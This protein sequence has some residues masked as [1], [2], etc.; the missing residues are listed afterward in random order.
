MNGILDGRL[1]SYLSLW[2]IDSTMA[3]SSFDKTF[4]YLSTSEVIRGLDFFYGDPTNS[5]VPLVS[6]IV[7]VNMY[8]E[9]RPL[10]EIDG[11]IKKTK[12]WINQLTLQL[13][14]QDFSK[15]VEKKRARHELNHESEK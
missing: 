5:Y 12:E 14:D 2:I 3:D 6:A 1:Y 9:Q 13:Q 8:G 10:E 7:I 4:E 11:Y 15:L